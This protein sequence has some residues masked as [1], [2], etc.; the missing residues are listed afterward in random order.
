[1][2]TVREIEE[3]ASGESFR[4]RVLAGGRKL[5]SL[6]GDAER[7]IAKR[8]LSARYPSPQVVAAPA[9]GPQTN[10]LDADEFGSQGWW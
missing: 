9:E 1:M 4:D 2:N 10:A 7:V 8:Y 5:E 3:V 6:F